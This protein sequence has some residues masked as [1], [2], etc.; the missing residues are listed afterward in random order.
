MR[1]DDRRAV[2]V[3]D[4]TPAPSGQLAPN[5]A[6]LD[7]VASTTPDFVYLF[8]LDGRFLYA[9]RRL[10]EV[11]GMELRDAIGR[12]TREL[13]YEQWHHDMHMREIAQVIETRRSIKG[14]VPFRAPRTGIFG[15]Y[16]YIFTPVIGADGEV[17]LIAGTT[18]DV[19]ERKRAEEDLRASEERL[20]AL[21]TATSHVVYRMNAD[22]T[23]MRELS[24]S[25]FIDDSPS[26][27]ASWLESFIHPD[28]QAEVMAAV[29]E[30]IRTK[31]TFELEH[32]TPR[33]DG[34]L[35][36]TLS[37]AVPLLGS[38]GEV[39][40]WVAAASDVTD[41]K[42]A[43][44]EREAQLERE[45]HG[46]EAAEA[47]LAVMSHELRTPV[48]TIYGTASL[49]ARDPHRGDVPDLVTD[50]Q[51]EAERLRRIIDD[52]L[53]LSGVERGHLRLAPEPVLLQR[54]VA[55]VVSDV[56]RAFPSV[57]FTNEVPATLPAVVADATAVRQ[58]LYNLVSNAAKYAGREGPVTI[59]A[60]AAD[61]SV[62]VSVLDEGPG[63]G[64]D[65][66]ALFALFYRASH[67]ARRA[68]GTGIGLY[69]AK[70]LLDAMGA[71]I[72][73]AT[74]ESGG[75]SFRFSLPRALD[76]QPS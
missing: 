26:P 74:R 31:R 57:T 1:P 16:E 70:A 42:R 45:R 72:T 21:V 47:F 27:D 30:A 63:L 4:G 7:A 29:R 2:A 55:D 58:V 38:D 15:I 12:T 60:T 69:V 10:L 46:R 33:L 3:E 56:S 6:L 62:H 23:E 44:E 5:L 76:D 71:T 17:E 39:V 8:D 43:E 68:S 37:R 53:V 54:A 28:D 20:R 51:D 52:L 13:G 24:G 49:L 48:T 75:A 14:E 9:N 36:W 32:R 11:W 40:E 35:G 18:R 67:S 66:A 64:D 25:G 41:R 73:G 34:T 50:L 65:P 59:A 22:W 61:A 19:T